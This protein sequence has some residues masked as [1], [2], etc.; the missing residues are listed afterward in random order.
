MWK[1]LHIV[2]YWSLK[3][4][5]LLSWFYLRKNL[6]TPVGCFLYDHLALNIRRLCSFSFLKFYFKT[7]YAKTKKYRREYKRWKR[8]QK[9]AIYTKRD[10]KGRCLFLTSIDS[11]TLRWRRCRLWRMYSPQRSLIFCGFLFLFVVSM[12]AF[13]SPTTVFESESTNPEKTSNKTVE[14]NEKELEEQFFRY[15][16]LSFKFSNTH[17]VANVGIIANFVFPYNSNFLLY[18]HNWC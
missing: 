13:Q 11:L 17:I 9:V 15:V 10:V 16:D 12:V 4:F 18:L 2:K 8:K 6:S 3:V 1:G 14:P 5:T 7:N